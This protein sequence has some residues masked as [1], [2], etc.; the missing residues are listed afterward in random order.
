MTSKKKI[1]FLDY[2]KKIFDKKWMQV[3]PVNINWHQPSELGDGDNNN[4][5]ITSQANSG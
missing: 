4:D 2:Y 3:V 1:S 5:S